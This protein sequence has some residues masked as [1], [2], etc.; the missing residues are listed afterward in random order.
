MFKEVNETV[1]KISFPSNVCFLIWSI[2]WRCKQINKKSDKICEKMSFVEISVSIT[3]VIYFTFIL[4]TLTSYFLILK[5]FYMS[6]FG[7]FSFAAPTPFSEVVCPRHNSV[8]SW[9]IALSLN[10]FS[11]VLLAFFQHPF[12]STGSLSFNHENYTWFPPKQVIKILG[13]STFFQGL[14]ASKFQGF[15]RTFEDF[16]GVVQ[17]A[18][19]KFLFCKIKTYKE[20]MCT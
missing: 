12:C 13:L 17:I 20:W 10:N 3:Q 6:L 7:C 18:T 1:K 15:S 14:F 2:K 19:T 4:W 16:Y 9:S 5:T 11:L 8:Q